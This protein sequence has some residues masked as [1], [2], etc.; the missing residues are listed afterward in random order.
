MENGHCIDK[1]KVC[2]FK[3]DCPT[4]GGSDEAQCGT[5]TFDNNNGTLCGWE[6]RSFSDL[7]WV[8]ATGATNMGPSSDHTTG[9]GFYITVPPNNLYKF[10]SLRSQTVG[11]AGV[12]CQLKF[13]Y[14]M[15][16]QTTM[17]SSKI[18]VYIRNENDNF[19]S[20]TYI[21]NIYHS[22]GPEWKQNV[23]N[24]GYQSRRFFIEIDG[25]PYEK[26]AIAIDDVEFYNCQ[27]ETA[28][29]LGLSINCTFENGWCNFFQNTTADF[30]WT[31]T[32][33]QTSSSNTGPN[34]DHTSGSGYYVFI[35]ASSPRIPGDH[36]RLISAL[37]Y[38]SSTAQC[39][40]FW[41]H[42]YGSD[43]GTLNVF[44][45]MI[46]TDLNSTSS[47]FVWTKSGTHG[48]QWHRAT[49]TL[50]NLNST[51]M[52]G[53]RIAFD[54]VVGDGFLGDIALDDIAWSPN[55]ICSAEEITTT[56]SQP[57]A[58]TTYPPTIYDCNFECNCTCN[59]KNDNTTKFTWTVTQAMVWSS[60]L[61]HDSDHTTGTTFGYYMY[62]KTN[63][64]VKLND[65][66]RLIS[67]DLISTNDEKCFRFYYRM[68]G[69]NI[70][71]LNIYARINGNLGKALWRREGNQGNQWLVGRLSLRGNVQQTIG[72]PYQLVVENIVGKN[73]LG[74]I[75][76]DD[77]AVN[78]GPCP[79]SSV[80]DFESSEQ[81]DYINDP[82][83][84]INWKRSQAEIDSSFPSIDVTYS[85]SYGHFMLLKDKN[86]TRPVYSRLITPHYFSTNG[87]CLRWYM[88]LENAATL[89]IK[90]DA[91]NI[92]NS[93]NLYTIHGAYGK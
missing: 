28:P 71:Q 2:D 51:D 92:L 57:V 11:P 32:N 46:S 17:N 56:L 37:Q 53:W 42:M 90:I 87:S 83:N 76:I 25:I 63:S 78:S 73:F 89:N 20:F 48:N 27:S 3:I 38:P 24:I 72:Q 84:I 44:V 74:Y 68:H 82:T 49:Q 54:G 15:N 88:L 64:S 4:P 59:W 23:I 39:L 31:R 81:C 8:L 7:N 65:T 22:T 61:V 29:E 14:Y 19:T 85:T 60:G 6:D 18:S 75:S 77:L 34:F 21:A 13:S 40:T 41:Y 33:I 1:R 52:Y 45:Q 86:T 69:S 16:T 58:S 12:E 5:C 36:A 30:Q 66:A 50:Y 80:C 93:T 35:E 43:I 70:Y 47:T 26:T 79:I 67:P 62:F 9:N 91:V 55:T 10:A